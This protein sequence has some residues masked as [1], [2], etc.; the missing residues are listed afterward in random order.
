MKR[1]TLLKRTGA[2]LV[3]VS[4]ASA[5]LSACSGNDDSG[6]SLGS[7]VRN[8]GDGDCGTGAAVFYTNPGHA[9]T[10]IDLTPEQVAAAVPSD[11]TL[12]GGDHD[13]TFFLSAQDFAD[14][15]LGMTLI[16]DNDEP[17]EGHIIQVVC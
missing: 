7:L 4:G 3:S 16:L 8:D 14:L 2:L 12:L 6:S 15:A 10:Q 9:H 11:Y 13:H 1:R 5:F 17:D